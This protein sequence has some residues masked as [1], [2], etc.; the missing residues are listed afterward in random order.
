MLTGF[1]L[2][3]GACALSI[4]LTFSPRTLGWAA[5][6]YLL[7]VPALVVNAALYRRRIRRVV[8]TGGGS[9]L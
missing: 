2:T 7:L 9:E 5:L 8:A 6:L 4:L 1:G 3:M